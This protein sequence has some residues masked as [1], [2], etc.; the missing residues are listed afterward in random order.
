[1]A[2]DE[3]TLSHELKKSKKRKHLTDEDADDDDAQRKAERKERKRMKKLAKEAAAAAEQD[4][5]TEPTSSE[6]KSKKSKSRKSKSDVSVDTTAVNT[7]ANTPA[8]ESTST[9]LTDNMITVHDGQ[10]VPFEA[11]DQVPIPE[12]LRPALSK[13]AQPT[14]IQACVWPPLFSGKDVVGIAETGRLVFF[15]HLNPLRAQLWLF[16]SGKT[17]AFSL[18]VIA[19]LATEIKSS[20]KGPS[21][22]ISV[23]VLSPTRELAIQSH[24]TLKELA[25]P[26]G[27]TS[28]CVYG[29]ASKD[30]QRKALQG[31]PKMPVRIIVAT[32]G[33]MLDFLQEGVISLSRYAGYL[34]LR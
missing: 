25:E 30:G 1:M 15:C 22:L 8:P 13:F 29:G 20:K 7:V 3:S 31:S 11:F 24:E 17:L 28:V 19:R 5:T 33:R 23:L 14:P 9:Y 16:N 6:H 10:I 34:T 2:G 4:T 18:P 27:F 21:A 32:P 26:F 12:Q